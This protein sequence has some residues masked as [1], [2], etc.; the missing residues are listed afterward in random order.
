M[1]FIVFDLDGTLSLNE[2]RNHFVRRKKPDWDSYLA[3]CSDDEIN[4]PIATLYDTLMCVKYDRKRLNRVEV[5]TGR[6]AV[7]HD[8]TVSWFERG[9]LLLPDAMLMRPEGDYQPD[10]ELKATWMAERGTPDL[11]FDDRATVVKMFRDAGVTAVQVA[12]GDF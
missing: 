9:G 4:E 5:W 8:V 3:A 2:H 11:V 10:T 1:V 12:K 7:T 6:S